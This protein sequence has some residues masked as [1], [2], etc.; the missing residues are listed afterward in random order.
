MQEQHIE[1]HPHIDALSLQSLA[2]R[3]KVL[4]DADL[5]KRLKHVEQL[6]LQIRTVVVTVLF[7]VVAF[8][9]GAKEMLKALWA[10]V[11]Q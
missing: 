5:D 4:E 7:M 1:A 11:G 10:G 9:I 6:N 8:G 2:A 3:I